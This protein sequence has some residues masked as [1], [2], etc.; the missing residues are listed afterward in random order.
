[1]TDQLN[2]DDVQ[3]DEPHRA[4]GHE[5][6]LYCKAEVLACPYCEKD[7]TFAATSAHR[8]QKDY[9]PL[10]ECK[11]CGA[12]V[13]CHK[14][15]NKPKGTVANGQD[16]LLRR[17]AH[18]AFDVLWK[19]KARRHALSWSRARQ[20]GYAWLSEQLGVDEA[21]IAELHGDALREVIRMCTPYVL[22]I[23]DNKN[24]RKEG[25]YAGR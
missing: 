8:Y 25:K 23:E 10:W 18:A 20:L 1:M 12:W 21:R 14:T 11:P 7:T 16:R 17:Q 13:S 5:T 3:D 6:C 15:T 22:M 9:G 24:R 19:E 4:S 2:F